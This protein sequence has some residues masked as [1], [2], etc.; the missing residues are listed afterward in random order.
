M[1]KKLE[2]SRPDFFDD[3]LGTKEVDCV[4]T[5]GELDTLM[6]EEGFDLLQPVPGKDE[7][8]R[9]LNG[10]HSPAAW[11]Q[12]VAAN[13]RRAEAIP[14]AASEAAMQADEALLPSLLE[15]PG[16]SSGSYLFGLMSA[17]W[18]EYVASHPELI[19]SSTG[20]AVPQL[21]M[22]VIRT[23]DFTEY[24]LRA[25]AS[26]AGVPGEILF[27]GAQCYGFRNLQNLV[28]KLQKQTGLRSKKGAAASS[29]NGEALGAAGA[30]RARPGRGRGMARGRGMVKRG[31]GA[32]AGAGAP[33]MASEVAA[34]AEG[35]ERGYDYV[36]VMA[37]PGGCVNG[38]GQIRPPATGAGPARNTG[39]SMAISSGVVES[40]EA[41][42][43]SAASQTP[44]VE[45]KDP[46]ASTVPATPGLNGSS[47]RS[48]LLDPEGYKS[49]WSTPDS[50]AVSYFGSN[51]Q[52]RPSVLSSESYTGTGGTSTPLTDV[53]DDEPNMT[54]GWQGTSKDWV[55][56]VERAYWVGRREE[57]GIVGAPTASNPS[58]PASAS[59]SASTSTTNK[60]KLLRSLVTAAEGVPSS[61]DSLAQ[62]IVDFLHA[63]ARTRAAAAS[64][65]EGGGET[66]IDLSYAHPLRTDY[67]SVQ[68]SDSAV[69]GLAV[70]W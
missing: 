1:T 70:Q 19:Q 57:A 56:R 7:L 4:I 37:C 25:P 6:V 46:A 10:I 39:I 49:G 53:N 43:D 11:T 40:T 68:D 38:G 58:A 63:D 21:D 55:R 61:V 17:T 44:A 45:S 66:P 36:E 52:A 20:P 69:N 28:R 41:Q 16:S 48:T 22:K 42:V 65:S 29:I 64:S 27:K 15:H 50:S 8:T 60:D 13:G 35:E 24:L 5:T 3:I 31:V 34:E 30:G 12:E 2:A 9:R 23:S 47:A 59:A 14:E 32:R 33:E 62:S 18:A 51:S 26:S 67:R 54:K